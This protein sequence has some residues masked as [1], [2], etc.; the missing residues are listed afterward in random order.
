M[1]PIQSQQ[2]TRDAR[3]PA[4][5]DHAITVLL[6]DDQVIVGEAVRRML[7]PEKDIIFHHCNNPMQAIDLARELHPTIILQ[8]L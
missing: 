7:A 2:P 8:D 4:L 5:A 6:V 3:L 1:Q